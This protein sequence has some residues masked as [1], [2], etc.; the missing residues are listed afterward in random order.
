[1]ARPLFLQPGALLHNVA[2]DDHSMT[3][4]PGLVDFDDPLNISYGYLDNLHNSISHAEFEI[5]CRELVAET[6]SLEP[7]DFPTAQATVMRARAL[8]GLAAPSP[9]VLKAAAA[10]VQHQQH[11]PLHPH[12]LPNQHYQHPTAMLAEPATPVH[13]HHPLLAAM[14]TP[15]PATPTTPR[16][17]PLRVLP[18]R[19]RRPTQRE[20]TNGDVAGSP[21][22]AWA[23][24]PDA[25]LP[26]DEE[27]SDEDAEV[28]PTKRTPARR[29]RAGSVRKRRPDMTRDRPFLCK[30]KGCTK[31]YTK[32]SHLKAHERTHTG[33]RPFVCTWDGCDWK[34]ARSDELTRHLRK[35]TGSRPYVCKLC[36]RTFARS[37]HLAAHAK[38]HSGSQSHTRKRTKRSR[39]CD[40]DDDYDDDEDYYGSP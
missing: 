8:S 19:V 31:S 28:T 40:D 16:V 6:S 2:F 38:V 13:L 23:S 10:A 21:D 30:H 37:D 20:L 26:S 4:D 35:H 34:F 25:S 3:D 18:P 9:A 17:T 5:L 14:A 33:E 7:M 12:Q 1:M 22:S 24:S 15:V 36:G 11:H 32:G 29:G 39:Y 27:T